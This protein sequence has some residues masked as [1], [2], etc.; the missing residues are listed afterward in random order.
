MKLVKDYGNVQGMLTIKGDVLEKLKKIFMGFLPK[1]SFVLMV[2]AERLSSFFGA[3]M[4]V[5]NPT[6]RITA[7]AHMFVLD[8]EW[9]GHEKIRKSKQDSVLLHPGASPTHLMELIVRMG[10]EIRVEF[11]LKAMLFDDIAKALVE[12]NISLFEGVSENTTDLDGYREFRLY[13][14][15]NRVVNHFIR[16]D[17]DEEGGDYATVQLTIANTLG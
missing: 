16:V 17:N 15:A 8:D 11:Y 13:I 10:G 14:P 2:R 6:R 3:D 4:V 5:K 1:S 7:V 12:G 9:I